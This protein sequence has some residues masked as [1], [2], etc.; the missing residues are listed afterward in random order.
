MCTLTWETVLST[1]MITDDQPKDQEEG[2]EVRY[3][4]ID[5]RDGVCQSGS[6]PGMQ[7]DKGSREGL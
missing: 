5:R 6:M 1:Q 2:M 3:P 7:L 4:D